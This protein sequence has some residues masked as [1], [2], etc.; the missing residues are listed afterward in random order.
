MGSEE[1]KPVL[2]RKRIPLNVHLRG[3]TGSDAVSLVAPLTGELAHEEKGLFNFTMFPLAT[4]NRLARWIQ[5][6]SSEE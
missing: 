2:D 4:P 1:E 6:R 3:L 5:Q